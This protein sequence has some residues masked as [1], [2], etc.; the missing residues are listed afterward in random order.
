MGQLDYLGRGPLSVLGG[1]YGGCDLW[2]MGL[3]TLSLFCEK[4]GFPQF[5]RG[6]LWPSPTVAPEPLRW[7]PLG[8]RRG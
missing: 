3:F 6:P 7:Y 8:T 4:G 1:D 2:F 5:I